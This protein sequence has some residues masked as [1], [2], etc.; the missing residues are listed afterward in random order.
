MSNNNENEILRYLREVEADD[1]AFQLFIVSASPSSS[2]SSVD[3]GGGIGGVTASS[4]DL[5]HLSLADWTGNLGGTRNLQIQDVEQSLKI[6]Y[7]NIEY[8]LGADNWMQ[9]C[10]TIVDANSYPAIL[11]EYVL[12]S[13]TKLYDSNDSTKLK[14]P[15][16]ANLIHQL[17]FNLVRFHVHANVGE[18]NISKTLINDLYDN[19]TDID[20]QYQYPIIYYKFV[21]AISTG[22]FQET[23]NAMKRFYVVLR[24]TDDSIRHATGLWDDWVCILIITWFVSIHSASFEKHF[25]NEMKIMDSFY[26]MKRKSSIIKHIQQDGIKELLTEPYFQ[27]IQTTY[28]IKQL[29]PAIP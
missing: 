26:H 13:E 22:N 7:D 18:F 17:F 23:T 25:M 29:T 4:N 6:F 10:K 28:S 19:W 21:E 5:K 15:Y 27:K 8:S 12:K 1:T 24:S 11:N 2:G 9:L 20:A 3:D 16:Q 14:E